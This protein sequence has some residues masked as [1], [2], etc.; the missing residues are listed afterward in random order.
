MMHHFYIGDVIRTQNFYY[1][2]VDIVGENTL[3]L[4]FLF[5]RNT[6]IG[7]KNWYI[8]SSIYIKRLFRKLFGIERRELRKQLLAE[9]ESLERRLFSYEERLEVIDK[10]TKVGRRIME[11]YKKL[12]R[13]YIELSK[14]NLK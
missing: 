14:M 2:V 12:E 13:R 9:M 5:W 11:E 8:Y 1:K 7:I 10:R 3:K 4:R 6:I